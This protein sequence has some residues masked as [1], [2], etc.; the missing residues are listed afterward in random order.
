MLGHLP[1][2]HS[3]VLIPV[4]EDSCQRACLFFLVC[5]SPLQISNQSTILSFSFSFFV[6][7]KAARAGSSHLMHDDTST[8][9]QC[10]LKLQAVIDSFV[11][12]TSTNYVFSTDTKQMH[13]LMPSHRLH[14]HNLNRNECE[15]VLCYHILN[16]LCV[17]IPADNNLRCSACSDISG[18]CLS[19]AVLQD[20]IFGLVIEHVALCM[21]L[22]TFR[23]LCALIDI[24]EH[25]FAQ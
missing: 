7:S 24:C 16:G 3:W 18:S 5:L 12:E 9:D 6:P 14:D 10:P 11:E 20:I 1:I 15:H 8:S 19:P 25:V 21:L 23:H 2:G 4:S 13:E 17:A 22:K